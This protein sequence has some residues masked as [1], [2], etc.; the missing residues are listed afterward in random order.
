MTPNTPMARRLNLYLGA[1]SRLD[2]DHPRPCHDTGAIGTKTRQA[3][4]GNRTP[5]ISLEG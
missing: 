4:G 2:K 3:G 5:I 1:K